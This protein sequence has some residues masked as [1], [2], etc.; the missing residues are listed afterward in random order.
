MLGGLQVVIPDGE[1][2][3]ARLQ[4]MQTVSDVDQDHQQQS[5]GMF[6]HLEKKEPPPISSSINIKAEG[7]IRIRNF[8]NACFADNIITIDESKE[9]GEITDDDEANENI[10][11]KNDKNVMK[12][13]ET[14]Y[15]KEEEAEVVAEK[16]ENTSDTKRNIYLHCC[17]I[18]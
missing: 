9:E 12:T 5:R 14:G 3:K 1:I 11:S 15:A 13:K 16:K 8:A 4:Q 18:Y 17:L 10:E 7:K 2:I 6:Y